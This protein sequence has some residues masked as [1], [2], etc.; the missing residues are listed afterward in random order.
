[1][2]PSGDGNNNHKVEQQVYQTCDK[3]L[4]INV[5]RR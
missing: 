4:L 1:M 3:C 5:I 2:N